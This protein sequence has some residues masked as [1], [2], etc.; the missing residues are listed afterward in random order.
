MGIQIKNMI[1][2]GGLCLS[3]ACSAVFTLSPM[4]VYAINTIEY[5]T[6]Y[7]EPIEES[8][9]LVNQNSRNIFTKIAKKAIN[10]K[11]R[12]V[13]F[14][15]KVAGKTVAKNVNKFFTPITRA[16]KPLLKWSEIPGQAVYDA[17]FTAIINAGGSR[18][19]AANVANAV[20]EVLEW[21]L[22]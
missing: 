6:E 14:A 21:T 12:L 8:D 17:I 3:I 4:T 18:S 13:N 22:F 5:E 1:V 9:Y 10:N 7:M 19:V 20:R 16:L 15:E 2:V 11:A